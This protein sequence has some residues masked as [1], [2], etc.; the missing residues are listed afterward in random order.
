MAVTVAFLIG[1]VAFLFIGILYVNTV[2]DSNY[3]YRQWDQ[4]TKHII[5]NRVRRRSVAQSG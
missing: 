1:G 5:R 4:V 2:R 3:S